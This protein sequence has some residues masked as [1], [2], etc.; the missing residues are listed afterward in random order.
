MKKLVLIRHSKTEALH[1]GISDFDRQ[2]KPRGKKD[3]ELIARALMEKG[4]APDLIISSPALRAL[5]TAQIIAGTCGV[6]ADTIRQESFIYDGYTTDDFIRFLAGTKKEFNTIYVIGHNPDIAL[7]AINLTE[8]NFFHFPTT[9]AAV[10]QFDCQ[11]WQEVSAREGKTEF[12]INPKM[13]KD[14]EE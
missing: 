11:N 1:S 8:D 6:N 12:Y 3:A 4:Y 10:I 13:L 14:S 2:L 5:Q 7:M 9:A